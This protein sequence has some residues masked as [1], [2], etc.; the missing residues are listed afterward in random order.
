MA[1]NNM[2]NPELQ[3]KA[4]LLSTFQEFS[5]KI[6][7]N[8]IEESLKDFRKKARLHATLR[9]KLRKW[10]KKVLTGYSN[11]II[12]GNNPVLS[13]DLKEELR[14]ILNNHY[15]YVSDKFLLF[16]KE[17]VADLPLK[18][19]DKAKDDIL[20][21]A[22]KLISQENNFKADKIIQTTQKDMSRAL[23]S[24]RDLYQEWIP[25]SVLAKAAEGI[26]KRTLNG[27][28]KGRSITSTTWIAEGT[29]LTHVAEVKQPLSN[30]L[31]SEAAAIV[32]D[33]E[34][35]A[36]EQA[37]DAQELSKITYSE[38]GKES[39]KDAVLIA[40][41]M[42][43][44]EAQ[45]LMERSHKVVAQIKMWITMG[46][47]KVRASHRAANGQTRPDNIPFNVGSSLLMYPADGQMGAPIREIVRCR[48]F[49]AYL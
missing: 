12:L 20:K 33:D 35:F 25:G 3:F 2:L 7:D 47:N 30:A 37:Q 36:L 42:K 16:K 10:Q 31:N 32:M 15:S 44:A 23:Q 19:V 13:N 24:A 49:V 40:I 11:N 6:P 28:L 9:N 43:M 45:K 48:C 21:G 46:D 38:T 18:P 22:Q 26:L 4:H 14:G 8:A 17:S 1:R 39:G 27:R 5:A 41:G 34:E 29:R